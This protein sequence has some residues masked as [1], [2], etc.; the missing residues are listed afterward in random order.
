MI[1]IQTDVGQIRVSRGPVNDAEAIGNSMV[2]VPY[3][4]ISPRNRSING[5]YHPPLTIPRTLSQTLPSAHPPPVLNVKHSRP[6]T[7]LSFSPVDHNYLATGLERHR[8]DFS[9]LVWDVERAISSIPPDMDDS[10]Q[11]PRDRLDPTH[12]IPKDTAEI[13][14][15]QHYCP[16][17]HI[18]DVAFM[19]LTIHSLLASANSK[20]IRLTI[21]VYLDREIV[22]PAIRLSPVPAL[23]FNGILAPSMDFLRIAITTI[24]LRAGKLRRPEV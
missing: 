13:K 17:E 21:C 18:N 22:V 23:L 14:N 3:P 6:V 4:S 7:S 5:S 20:V 9:L 12:V 1:G 24:G 11:R 19:P 8:S 15:I 10:W 2:I 16:S